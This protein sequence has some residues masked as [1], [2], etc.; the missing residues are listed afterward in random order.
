MKKVSPE[1]KPE[2]TTFADCIRTVEVTKNSHL[3]GLIKEHIKKDDVVV[4]KL[5]E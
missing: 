2:T 3:G 1:K 4:T 5:K